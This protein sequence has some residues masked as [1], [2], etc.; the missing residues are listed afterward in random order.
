MTTEEKFTF[1]WRGPF[2]QWYRS[3]F[4]VDGQKYNCAEQYMMAMKA[5]L[6][7]DLHA[8]SNIMKASTPRDQKRWGREVK[9]FVKGTWEAIAR[10]IVFRGNLEKFS[11][12][13]ALQDTLFQTRGTTLVEASPY[14]TIWGI[15]LAADDPKAQRRDYW[16]GKNWL[17]EVLT[18][19]REQL[20]GVE[21]PQ[22]SIKKAIFDFG[23]ALKTD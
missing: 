3:D 8:Y 15:G 5:Q 7:G 6:F 14:D 21:Q 19:V 11:Q 10:D 9:Y 1:F 20:C 2:S 4:T 18:A 13:A 22:F 17:G 23:E 16:R 12:N